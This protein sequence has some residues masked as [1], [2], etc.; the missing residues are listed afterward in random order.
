MK[1][2]SIIVPCF[3]EEACIETFYYYANKYLTSI[4]YEH[5]IIFINDGSI[6]DTYILAKKLASIDDKVKVI[7]FSKNFGQESAILAGLK[8]CSGDCVVVMDCDLQNPIE[9][10]GDMLIKWAEGYKIVHAKNDCKKDNWFKKLSTKVYSFIFN[11]LADNK[12]KVVDSEFKLYDRQVV[13]ELLNLPEKQI[14]LKG[15]T[16]FL[17]FKQT[18][19]SFTK[20][21]R[22][23]GKSCYKLT[24]RVQLGCSNIISSSNKLLML[25]FYVGSILSA[26]AGIVFTIFTTLLM[27]K[28]YLP[29]TAWLFPTIIMLFSLVFIFSGIHNAYLGKIY[30]QVKNRPNYIIEDTVNFNK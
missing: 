2:I 12:V 7:N 13:N 10:V 19:I 25:P 17:G 30:E 29:L 6:D 16:G 24:K 27:F 18:T 9:T 1:K 20:Q 21:N 5:E 3:N 26:I 11:L 8:H 14:C 22:K 28:I 23:A 4:N 15:V